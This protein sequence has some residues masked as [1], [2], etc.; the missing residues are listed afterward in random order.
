MP[1][2]EPKL[3]SGSQKRLE[4]FSCR[5]ERTA[6]AIEVLKERID[7]LSRRERGQCRYLLQVLELRSLDA[8]RHLA[9]LASQNPGSGRAWN[10]L[11]ESCVEIEE[12]L[13]FLAQMIRNRTTPRNRRTRG[14]TVPSRREPQ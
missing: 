8:G 3:P 12:H 11:Q 1:V 10:R 9:A 7:R 13:G 6:S 14:T 4:S 2:S 5:L